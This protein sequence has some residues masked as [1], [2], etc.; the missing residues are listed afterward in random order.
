[1]QDDLLRSDG[2][3][4]GELGGQARDRIVW[5]WRAAPRRSQRRLGTLAGMQD[6]GGDHRVTGPGEKSDLPARAMQRQ[7]QPL[8]HAARTEDRHR[9]LCHAAPFDAHVSRTQ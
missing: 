7:A 6:E 1:M 5:N 8:P 4:G 2:S 3:L 9:R